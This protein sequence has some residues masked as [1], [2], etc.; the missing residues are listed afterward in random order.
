MRWFCMRA[1]VI[2]CA[3]N[4]RKNMW[5][6]CMQ[7][8]KESRAT[9][10][11]KSSTRCNAKSLAPSV[12]PTNKKVPALASLSLSLPVKIAPAWAQTWV[13]HK[14]WPGSFPIH[15]RPVL[16]SGGS[17]KMTPRRCLSTSLFSGEDTKMQSLDAITSCTGS[18]IS[19]SMEE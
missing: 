7:A 6:F 8:C 5:W 1:S 2:S 19:P 12:H 10:D 15:D 14:T 17:G 3:S 16:G 11:V 18:S 4:H 9:R 13:P